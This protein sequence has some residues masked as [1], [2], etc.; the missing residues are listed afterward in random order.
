MQY[1]VRREPCRPLK[2]NSNSDECRPAPD[3]VLPL[4]GDSRRLQEIAEDALNNPDSEYCAYQW[5]PVQM[6]TLGMFRFKDGDTMW[7]EYL[8][9]M[10][11]GVVWSSPRVDQGS[12]VG[13]GQS[14]TVQVLVG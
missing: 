2:D 14:F 12:V 9:E 4:I 8:G 3:I 10:K 6:S 7:V 11:P 13:L 5:V 1:T